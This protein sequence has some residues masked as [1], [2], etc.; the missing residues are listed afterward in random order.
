M[1]KN[2]HTINYQLDNSLRAPNN[3]I[4]EFTIPLDQE[5]QLRVNDLISNIKKIKNNNYKINISSSSQLFWTICKNTIKNEEAT[6]NV[7]CWM[8]NIVHT[9]WIVQSNNYF[10]QNWNVNLAM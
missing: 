8:I 7:P 10:W 3:N 1:K 6:V 5:N 2:I 9:E 4:K